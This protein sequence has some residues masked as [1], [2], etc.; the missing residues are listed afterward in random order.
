MLSPSLRLTKTEINSC[1]ASFR[2][3]VTFAATLVLSLD[4]AHLRYFKFRFKVKF[5]FR[6]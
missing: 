2:P 6:F 3:T 5:E 1:L 4:L